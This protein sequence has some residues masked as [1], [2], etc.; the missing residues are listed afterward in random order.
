MMLQPVIPYPVLVPM[1]VLLTALVL[2]LAVKACR[3][4]PRGY[5]IC[6]VGLAVL[7]L[8]SGLALLLNP[9]YEE[10]RPGKDTPLWLV[11][12][13]VSASMAAP[14]QD[15][16]QAPSRYA[17]AMQLVEPLAEL[18]RKRNACWLMLGETARRCESAEPLKEHQPADAASRVMEELARQ[19]EAYRR[20]GVPLA[21]M[22][23]LTDGREHNPRAWQTLVSRAGAAGCPVH[24]LP[25]GTTWQEPDVAVSTFYPLVHSYPGVETRLR[26]TLR[27]ERLPQGPVRVELCDAEGKVLQSQ[28]QEL[29]PGA[30][31]EVSFPLA[32]QEGQYLV[33]AVPVAG[34][35]RTDNNAVRLTVR[36]VNSRIRVLF[37]EGAPYWDSKFLAQY[38]RAQQVFDV[39][40]VHRLTDKRYYH[41]NSGDADS[42]PSESHD[43]PT[44][45][46]AFSRFDI[47]VLGKGMEHFLTDA[48]V[49]ALQRYVR[50][51]G[52]VLVLARGRCHDGSLP[53]MDAL[54]PFVR[55]ADAPVQARM[56]P[57][58][59]G[60]EQG[61]FGALLPGADDEA[62][63]SLP[64]LE[65]V[66]RVAELR[67]QTT[68]LADAQAADLPML[69]VMRCGLG[70]VTAINGEGLWKWD[71][72]PD[73]REQRN[74][75]RDFWRYY[76]PWLQT[77]AEFMPGYDLSLHPDRSAVQ[78]GQPVGC[79]MRWRGVGRPQTV[80]LQVLSLADGKEV[81]AYDAVPTAAGALPCWSCRIGEL[82]AGEY[83]LQAVV[84]GEDTPAP[85]CR[86]TV[87]DLPGE[88]DNLNANAE[89][90]V[91]VAEMTGGKV[92]RA[93][94]TQAELEQILT[95]PP[96]V[97]HTEWVYCSLWAKWQVL[98]VMVL[99]LGAMWLIRRR[100]GLP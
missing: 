55:T 63:T 74:L 15:D 75:Y 52:G 89:A 6:C 4:L 13:D 33:R 22:V 65:D 94:M 1:A 43:M 83:L 68:V 95:L 31:A 97:Q 81:A 88:A 9:G 76:L 26:A 62:W 16:A 67:P 32:V 34:E 25:L 44:T 27:K 46:E 92:L 24:V 80:K 57:S 37:A 87:K 30:E 99:C 79:T 86:L 12:V 17:T 10:E 61:L 93:D 49:A 91:R 84:P 20:K 70:A 36:A 11:G 59:A 23:L 21:G 35:A 51:N 38:L 3:P 2:W 85:E 48:S 100:K 8:L 14:V 28:V 78:K 45:L 60:V 69:A 29:A 77:A 50:E 72:Y 47:V 5:K 82:P 53:A 41:I 40:S 39:R 66:C 7:A 54:D 56:C 96:G 90:V 98:T 58:L 18:M 19:A 71:F 42:S 64:E 73:A